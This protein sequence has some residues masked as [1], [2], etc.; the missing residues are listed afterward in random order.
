MVDRHR[1]LRPDL[2]GVGLLLPRL[3]RLRDSPSLKRSTWDRD[4]VGLLFGVS[5]SVAAVFGLA[6]ARISPRVMTF[7]GVLMMGVGFLLLGRAESFL[8]YAFIQ[9]PLVAT[10]GFLIVMYGSGTI[11]NNW[12]SKRRGLAFAI[13]MTGVSFGALLVNLTQFLIDG[14]GWRDTMLVLGIIVL[15]AGLP[16]AAIMRTRPEDE[17]LLPDGE[18]PRPGVQA[19]A[20][21][22]RR[23]SPACR[24]RPHGAS[25]PGYADV[26]GDEP[27]VHGAELRHHRPRRTLHPRHRRQGL[28]RRCRRRD[29]GRVRGDDR[30]QPA[31]LRATWATRWRRN[32]V[33]G[34]LMAAI[35]GSML[36]MIWAETLAVIIIFVAALRRLLGRDRRRD[37]DGAPR[38]ILRAAPLRRH[39]EPSPRSS[40]GSARSPARSWPDRIFE[41]T[42]SY[43]L[44]LRRLRRR[45]AHLRHRPPLPAP[46]P[47][48]YP[49][50]TGDGLALPRH[51][52]LLLL[53]LST[54]RIEGWRDELPDR[55]QAL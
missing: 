16:L 9:A 51:A 55:R 11:I 44:G 52:L 41:E 27:R 46:A 31:D 35:A 28:H 53:L 8:A 43:Q 12:F 45:R 26:L 14:M 32:V 23:A 22:R 10:G 39:R 13:G 18:P 34:V 5:S 40:L 4:S 50:E 7:A 54:N 21:S 38:R 19:P 42:G 36:I 48:R 25:G 29:A 49:D 24:Q 17:G 30:A 20:T 33:A 2:D 37:V 3:L 6:A 1:R 47:A 15:A